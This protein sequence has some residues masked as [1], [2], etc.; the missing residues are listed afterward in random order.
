M[1]AAEI[2]VCEK[3][4]CVKTLN[5]GGVIML[6]PEE[7]FTEKVNKEIASMDLENKGYLVSGEL[8]PDDDFN[9]FNI[10][11]KKKDVGII[12]YA[13]SSELRL[14]YCPNKKQASDLIANIGEICPNLG[15]ALSNCYK[16]EM[17]NKTKPNYVEKMQ[18]F[19]KNL[20]GGEVE[21]GSYTGEITLC[22]KAV[23]KDTT[24][25]PKPKI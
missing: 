25:I 9:N 15:E 3:S 8:N 4:K 20:R 7:F 12:I 18:F 22:E 16:T 2:V 14:A 13:T 23:P 5:M 19:T 11:T 24:E 1:V 17:E 21:H 6:K 10:C